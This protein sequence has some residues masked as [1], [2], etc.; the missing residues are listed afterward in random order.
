MKSG[1][2]HRSPLVIF[3]IVAD[4]RV[5]RV[6]GLT[7]WQNVLTYSSAVDH[8]DIL[9]Q[10]QVY[11]KRSDDKPLLPGLFLSLGG[12]LSRIDLCSL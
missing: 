12:L 10:S 1:M 5:A 11:L 9:S 2:A 3:C 6:I 8:C 7:F 4:F